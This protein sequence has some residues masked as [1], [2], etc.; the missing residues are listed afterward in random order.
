MSNVR[1]WLWFVMAFGTS[2][3]R[4]WDFVGFY[5][6]IETAYEAV[7]DA[8]HMSL[9]EKERKRI[10]TT[11]IEQCDS[12]IEY[13]D[14]KGYRII[15]F[16]DKNYPPL[17]RNIYNPPAVLFC[18]GNIENFLDKLSLSCVGTRTPSAYSADV[19]EK[20]CAELA[21]RDIAIVSGFAVGL[22]SAA[23]RGA[24]SKNGCTV[25]V[26]AC[27]LDVDYPRE[28]ADAKKLIAVKGAVIT[29]YLPGTHPDRFCFQNRNRI[30]SGLSLG[31]FVTEADERSGALITANHAIEQGRALFCLP[32]GDVFDKR[33]HGVIK[34][35]RDG[36]IPVFNHLDVM[37]EYYI[38]GNYSTVF[39]DFKFP[40][41]YGTDEIPYRDTR[42]RKRKKTIPKK[43]SVKTDEKSETVS[44]E[45][46]SSRIAEKPQWEECYE[47]L[48]EEQK[49]IVDC[50]RDGERHPDEIGEMTGMSAFE[51]MAVMTEL[52][53][54]GAAELLPDRRYRLC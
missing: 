18:M 37:N 12:I 5:R 13:C 25:A 29:E 51:I 45:K 20:I 1:Y 46:D 38:S 10:S 39:E 16:E 42:T 7:C 41:Y 27:D 47:Q 21:A 4:I 8:K 50:L 26:L 2:N 3:E 9:N 6:D 24:L 35:L 49:I 31:T 34:Y 33:Y 48:E 17:L 32:P 28:N 15:T 53:M 23:H 14:E 52:E 40:E 36:A 43:S 22:D 54:I 30:I 11:H 44:S 19:T